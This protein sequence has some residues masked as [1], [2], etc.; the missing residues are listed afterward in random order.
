MGNYE[1]FLYQYKITSGKNINLILEDKIIRNN[2]TK[3]NYKDSKEDSYENFIQFLIMNYNG[4]S[5]YGKGM[6]E[7]KSLNL[8]NNLIKH[9]LKCKPKEAKYFKYL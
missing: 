4:W 7:D 8:A 1:W 2:L 9:F 5:P 6:P 3:K